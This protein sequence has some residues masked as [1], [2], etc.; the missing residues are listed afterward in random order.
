LSSILAAQE[1]APYRPK[2]TNSKSG[3]THDF[4][5]GVLSATGRLKDGDRAILVIDVGKGGA[6]DRGGL[7]AGDQIVA[8][9]GRRPS[10]FSNKT[11]A[12]LAGPQTDLAVAIEQ[13]SADKSH[14]LQLTV[15]RKDKTIRL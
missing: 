3:A 4:P 10:L 13:A 5:L 14:R 11:D 7:V 6:A 2:L 12:G 8:I 15:K 1:T 9:R